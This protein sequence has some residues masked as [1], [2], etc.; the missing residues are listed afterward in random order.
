M[1]KPGAQYVL[2]Y[3]RMLSLW[4]CLQQITKR[5]IKLYQP[6]KMSMLITCKLVYT[7]IHIM[8]LKVTGFKIQKNR[9]F[10]SITSNGLKHTKILSAIFMWYLTLNTFSSKAIQKK[11]I[12][13][14]NTNIQ[15]DEI[16]KLAWF[17]GVLSRLLSLL[18][19]RIS[20]KTSYLFVVSF[21]TVV[22]YC[23][24]HCVPNTSY[25]PPHANTMNWLFQTC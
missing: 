16:K 1:W 11:N 21:K 12:K 17:L 19:M 23:Y 6:Y 25:T 7:S 22:F 9:V 20:S 5:G 15:I 3:V 18:R 2:C 8:P 10:H 24:L 4:D 14:Q 13:I